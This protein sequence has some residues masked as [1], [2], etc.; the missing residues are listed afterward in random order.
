MAHYCVSAYIRSTKMQKWLKVYVL[1]S[2]TITILHHVHITMVKYIVFYM[3][4]QIYFKINLWHLILLVRWQ[5]GHLARKKTEWW[6]AGVVTCL[7]P[8]AD[9]HM[10]H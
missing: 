5:E 2:L 6:G 7:G 4:F 9:L 8:D 10:A 1:A 3:K